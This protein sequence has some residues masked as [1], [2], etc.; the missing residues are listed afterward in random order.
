MSGS[1]SVYF[2]YVGIWITGRRETINSKVLTDNIF[3]YTRSLYF[4]LQKNCIAVLSRKWYMRSTNTKLVW[5]NT[6]KIYIC[7]KFDFKSWYIMRTRDLSLMK[8]LFYTTN[9]RRQRKNTKM[10]I[11]NYYCRLYNRQK[12]FVT[13]IDGYRNLYQIKSSQSKV[14]SSN[15]PAI[16]VQ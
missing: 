6:K 11:R 8:T 5:L 16:S 13:N 15:L 10:K 14:P 1:F 4:P 9:T 2:C 12:R 3:Q 7:E